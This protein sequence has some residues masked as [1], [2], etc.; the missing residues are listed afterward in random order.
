VKSVVLLL[1]CEDV[2]SGRKLKRQV[3]TPKSNVT[4][5]TAQTPRSTPS[6]K[7]RQAH[8][9]DLHSGSVKRH[10]RGSVGL[11]RADSSNRLKSSGSNVTPSGDDAPQSKRQA[12]RNL[13][14]NIE[15]SATSTPVLAGMLPFRSLLYS[16]EFAY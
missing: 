13:M 14:K 5:P 16:R 12:K 7:R 9:V 4:T 10:R 15:P 3:S 11:D 2:A 8:S 1:I 6:R